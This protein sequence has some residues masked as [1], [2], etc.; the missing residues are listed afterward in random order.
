MT[1]PSAI[2]DTWFERRISICFCNV[3]RS[4]W[5]S[6]LQPNL[7]V[8]KCPTITNGLSCT[9]TTFTPF[10]AIIGCFA[11]RFPTSHTHKIF[12]HHDTMNK[13]AADVSCFWHDTLCEIKET[14]PICSNISKSFYTTIEYFS[15]NTGYPFHHESNWIPWKK[16]PFTTNGMGKFY[17]KF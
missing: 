16:Y 4:N 1:S 11:V 17:G 12:S 7:H 10:N 14:I 3:P 13:I 6:V 5:C 15:N 2:Y 8:L 9:S